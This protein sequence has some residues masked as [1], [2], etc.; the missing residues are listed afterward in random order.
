MKNFD[1]AVKISQK[2]SKSVE[3]Y[4]W[5]AKEMCECMSKRLAHMEKRMEVSVQ[6][7]SETQRHMHSLYFDYSLKAGGGLRW[8]TRRTIEEF[9][10]WRAARMRNGERSGVGAPLLICRSARLAQQFKT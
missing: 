2:H 1:N 9:T 7:G 6:L 3:N 10:L 5:S 4:L 8:I